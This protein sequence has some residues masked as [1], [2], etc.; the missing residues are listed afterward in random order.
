MQDAPRA[1]H[2]YQ[3]N[4][5]TFAN[6][7]DVRNVS[8]QFQ[9]SKRL[10]NSA[11]YKTVL[12]KGKKLFSPLFILFIL[13]NNQKKSRIGITVSKKV[14]KRAIDRNRIKRQVRETF[15][16][17]QH[18]GPGFDAVLIANAAA[19]KKDNKVIRQA[20]EQ[21]WQKAGQYINN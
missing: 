5:Q 3:R 2:V 15:R 16:I 1:G 11:Q 18:A 10:L 6:R 19:G 21:V 9:K 7:V 20:L 4:H 17:N 13:P 12:R 14:S 8:A